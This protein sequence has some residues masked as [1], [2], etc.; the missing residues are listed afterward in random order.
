MRRWGMA[1]T[2]EIRPRSIVWLAAGVAVAVIA[3]L[4]LSSALRVDAAP[5]DDDSTFVP[6]DG[7]RAFD[8]RP[9]VDQVGARSTPLGARETHTQQITGG[10]G[11]CVGALAIPADAVA[12]S[13]NVTAVGP[14]TQSNLRLFPADVTEVP[15]LS[16][17]NFSAGQAPFPNKVDVKLSPGGA[18]NIYNQNGSVFVVGD[19]NGYYTNSSLTELADRVADLERKLANVDALTVDGEPTVRFSGVNVQV[20]DGSGDTRC[21]G[22]ELCNGRG[23]LVVGY[24]E[25]GLNAVPP[26]RNGSHNIVSG[27]EHSYQ[28]YG[29][30]VF[31]SENEVRDPYATITGGE[32]HV[33]RGEHATITGGFANR[34]TADHSH[35]SGGIRNEATGIRSAVSGGRNNTAAGDDSTVG[36]GANRSVN[37]SDNWRAGTLFEA[38]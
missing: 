3:T 5:G 32:L 21:G 26:I 28:S 24:N 17:L 8:F 10:V 36:G 38:D 9:G 20:V 22:F 4:W 11:E 29:G 15:L 30:V 13:M 27:T 23:N 35:V 16:N 14:T 33:A 2:V 34:T 1:V 7:C 18:I 12:V 6:T 19:V 37:A 31:G 25:Q